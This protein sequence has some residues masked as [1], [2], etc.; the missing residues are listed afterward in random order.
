MQSVI[1]PGARRNDPASLNRPS[2]LRVFLD[3]SP[4]VSL[5]SKYPL[6]QNDIAIP[7]NE[8]IKAVVGFL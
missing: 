2:R 7:G 5:L 3:S 4:I 6:F 1:N 8:F